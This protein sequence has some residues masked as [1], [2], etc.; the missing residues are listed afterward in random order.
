VTVASGAKCPSLAIRLQRVPAVTVSIPDAQEGTIALC[1]GRVSPVR[2]Y[3]AI[4]LAVREGKLTVPGCAHGAMS[5]VYALDPQRRLGAVATVR[6]GEPTPAVR[7]MKCGSARVRVLGPD[8]CPCEGAI[9]SLQL[10]ADRDRVG[11]ASVTCDAQPVDWFDP[12]NYPRR[13]ATDVNGF[14]RLPALIPGARYCVSVTAHGVR[15][16]GD[17]FVARSGEESDLPDLHLGTGPNAR[18]TKGTSR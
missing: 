7:L 11:A 5:T 8:G 13:P 14:V 16:T 3:A 1:S 17:A 4:P 12:V 9:V 10:L 6:P 18:L 2:G 15:E